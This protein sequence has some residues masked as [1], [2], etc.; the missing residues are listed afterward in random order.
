MSV[1]EGEKVSYNAKILIYVKSEI[2]EKN[3][4]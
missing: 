4:S 3:L 2:Q 1:E